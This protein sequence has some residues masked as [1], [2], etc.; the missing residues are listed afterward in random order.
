MADAAFAKA[1]VTSATTDGA[2]AVAD[3]AFAEAGV[4]FAEADGAFGSRHTPNKSPI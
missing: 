2:F 1:G 4:T 3:E